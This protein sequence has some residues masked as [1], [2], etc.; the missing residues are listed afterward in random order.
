VISEGSFGGTWFALAGTDSRWILTIT[1]WED[2]R[3]YHWEM[4]L[5]SSPSLRSEGVVYLRDQYVIGMIQSPF[6]ETEFILMYL[7]DGKVHVKLGT[8]RAPRAEVIFSKKS[9]EF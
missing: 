6:Q 9:N 4:Y 3:S 5:S 8:R 7:L 1:P 2:D